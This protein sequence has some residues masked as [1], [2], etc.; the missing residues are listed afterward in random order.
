M[1]RVKDVMST[2]I[3]A[4]TPQDNVFEAAVIMKERN[5]GVVPVC[6]GDTLLGVVTDRDLVI[7]GLAEKRPGSFAITN[8]MSKDV[9]SVNSDIDVQ[10]AAE[11]MS[12]KQ[13]RRLPVID[14]NRLVGMLSLG[15]IALEEQSNEAAEHA[16]S[17]ISEPPHLTH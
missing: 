14:N 12:D 17:E 8:V 7:R 10:Q 5:V 2:D 1:K 9:E 3:A 4:L 15:D 16:L 11:L 13:I 6:E